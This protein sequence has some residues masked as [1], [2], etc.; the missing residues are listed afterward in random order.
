[1]MAQEVEGLIENPVDLVQRLLQL[2]HAGLECCDSVVL[3]HAVTLASG[4]LVDQALRRTVHLNQ[5]PGRLR[6]RPSRP[7]EGSFALVER[8]EAKLPRGYDSYVVVIR[9]DGPL[10]RPRTVATLWGLCVLSTPTTPLSPSPATL[11]IAMGVRRNYQH[12]S[13]SGS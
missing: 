9:Q 11:C 1:M 6:P 13:A 3:G 10:R 7:L 8:C 5:R 4:W 12:F 2:V